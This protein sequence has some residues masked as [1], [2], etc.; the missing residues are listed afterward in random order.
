M[1]N[2]VIYL[3]NKPMYYSPLLFKLRIQSS[4]TTVP[5]QAKSFLKNLCACR[6]QRYSYP[7]A[8]RDFVGLR[9]PTSLPACGG[10]L[11]TVIKKAQ[12][13]K[14]VALFCFR[15]AEAEGFEPPERCRSTV[16]KTAA[17]DHSATP[18]VFY[19]DV[20]FLAAGRACTGSNPNRIANVEIFIY[21]CEY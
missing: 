4:W 20:A 16:F 18:P 10:A 1:S 11:Q 8:S 14:L 12:S 21:F 7:S 2:P 15:F 17:I 3:R 9:P 19:R 5:T 13:S 6:E